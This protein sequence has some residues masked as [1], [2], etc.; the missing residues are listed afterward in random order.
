MG[1]VRAQLAEA[2]KRLLEARQQRKL[3]VDDKRLAGW[4]GLLLHALASAAQQLKDPEF[5]AA[6]E[7]LHD[8]LLTDLW[9]GR[10]LFRAVHE[11]KPIG[12][13]SLADYAY[14]AQGLYSWA[15]VRKRLED[16]KMADQLL[17]IAWS[18]FY[19]DKGWISGSQALLPGMPSVMAQED[20]ALPAPAAAAI[21]LQLS[22]GSEDPL[23][24]DKAQAILKDTRLA[25]QDNPFW[26][27]SDVKVLLTAPTTGKY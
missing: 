9:D 17:N 8:Y 21:I 20:G 14:V 13:A 4:N 18:R 7:R 23:L 2:K 11:G 27:A 1:Q 25:I 15:K 22:L 24:R 16:R 19:T 12:Q 5:L 26:Y 3:P 10:Q 6:A